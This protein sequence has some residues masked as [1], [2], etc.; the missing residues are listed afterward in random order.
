MVNFYSIYLEKGADIEQK[1][2]EDEDTPLNY[3]AYRR[4]DKIV[5]MLLDH[6]A[7]V[8]TVDFLGHTPLHSAVMH[9][10]D[11]RRSYLYD[12][13]ERRYLDRFD[14]RAWFH[15]EPAKWGE[16]EAV[17]PE[18]GE[19][20]VRQFLDHGAN[21]NARARDDK[22]AL[23]IAA[24]SSGMDGSTSLLEILL[25]NGADV[26]AVDS[27]GATAL[28]YAAATA[29]TEAVSILLANG[30]D[31]DVNSQTDTGD[32]PLIRAVR[33]RVKNL[34]TITLLLDHGANILTCNYNGLT[35][36]H[37]GVERYGSET[38]EGCNILYDESIVTYLLE[39]GADPD[40]KDSRGRTPLDQ[41][42]TN[43][44]YSLTIATNMTINRNGIVK[45]LLE[46]E[47]RMEGL[48]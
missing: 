22:T 24:I 39:H 37:Y 33:S 44:S 27:E 11:G 46:W 5:T 2:Y 38:M 17:Y 18:R 25:Q 43:E 21:I 41:A 19:S 48:F 40:S 20:I 36:L 32:T 10:Y 12:R 8:N 1:Q 26:A 45:L 29:C 28:H 23:H 7:D 47:K 31:V 15:V 6:G 14:Q 4:R 13:F 30:A 35:P 16:L 3:T 42:R 34:S 9:Y